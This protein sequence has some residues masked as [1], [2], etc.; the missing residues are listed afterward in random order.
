MP[1]PF[2]AMLVVLEGSDLSQKFLREVGKRDESASE[3]M[4]EIQSLFSYGG[5]L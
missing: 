3:S 4:G 1:R 2:L 5:V